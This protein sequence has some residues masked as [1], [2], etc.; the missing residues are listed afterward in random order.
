[1]TGDLTINGVDAWGAYGMNFEDG[2]LASLLTPP[3]LKEFAEA[4][5]RLRNGTVL[6]VDNDT[7]KYDSRDVLI[8]FHLVADNQEQ[9]MSRYNAL[10]NV[11]KAGKITLKTKFTSDTYRMVYNSCSQM[12]VLI[13]GMMK[14]SLKLIEP[15][16]NNRGAVDNDSE[17][18]V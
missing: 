7:T 12:S 15:N 11:L 10:C 9:L 16:P 1:M 2:A 17:I 13:N 4:K 8:Q 5:S 14:F 18:D 3:P 6:L